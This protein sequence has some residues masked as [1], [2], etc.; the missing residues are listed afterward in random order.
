M[1]AEDGDSEATL[2]KKLVVATAKDEFRELRDTEGYTFSE[3][4]NALRDQANHDADFLAEAHK[5]SEQL[6]HDEA[7]SDEDYVKYRDQINQK[8]KERGLPEI[9]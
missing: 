1:R 7:V 4:L 3:Y 8:L 2:E 6:Y 5:M 9:E